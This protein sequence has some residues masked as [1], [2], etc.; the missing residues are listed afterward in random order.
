M[1]ENLVVIII[2][3]IDQKD[4][5][6][7]CL[8]SVYNMDY[9]PF[10]IVVVDN[11]S[12]D[13]SSVA[14]KS[15]Y[16]KVYLLESESNLGVSGG[17]NLALNFIKKKFDFKYILLLDNDTII[18]KKALSEMVKSFN[19]KHNIG[20]VTPKCYIMNSP[21]IINYA[22]GMSVNLYTGNIS[23]IGIGEKDLG[24]FDK[25]CFINSSGGLCIIRKNVI[26]RVG[27]FDEKFNP[28]G[29]EDVD[30]SLRA[31]RQGFKIY[32]NPNAIIHHKGGK[33]GRG[34]VEEYEYAK[35]RNYFY[36]IRKHA[37]LPQLIVV[38]SLFPFKIFKLFTKELYHGEFK[39]LS[40]QIRGFLGQ[41]KRL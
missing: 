30:L 20:I 29:W 38:F 23:N 25:P 34:A 3:N 7:E 32:Y 9:S 1:K 19:S 12:K 21:S 37:N 15:K 2:L 17:R 39:I 26:N 27:I 13:G 18:D 24:Q 8:E 36:L 5:T 35:I 31:R 10:E 4:D 16:P 33:C 41:F 14:I 28:Y 6:L 40:A 11:G 22:G